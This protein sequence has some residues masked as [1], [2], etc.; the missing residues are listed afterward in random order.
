VGEVSERLLVTPR[1]AEDP[2]EQ[3]LRIQRGN[4]LIAASEHPAL[5]RAPEPDDRLVNWPASASVSAA[6][7]IVRAAKGLL[8]PKTRWA[9]RTL[10]W[11]ASTTVCSSWERRYFVALAAKGL[12]IPGAIVAVVPAMART[13]RA[14]S[15]RR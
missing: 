9:K 4:V 14:V 11:L 8:L 7:C 6:F 5:E 13:R 12:V 15:G 2:S 3:R 1:L 10:V